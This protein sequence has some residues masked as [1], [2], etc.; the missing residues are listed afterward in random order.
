MIRD[1]LRTRGLVAA[2]GFLTVAGMLGASVL[3][4]QAIETQ[5][6]QEQWGSKES[7]YSAAVKRAMALVQEAM[8]ASQESL[9][10]AKERVAKRQE[11]TVRKLHEHLRLIQEDDVPRVRQRHLRLR[12][13]GLRRIS[14]HRGGMSAEGILAQAEHLGLSDEQVD[15][16]RGA[17]KAHRRAGITRKAEIEIA[18]LDLKEMLADADTAD[19]NAVEA[20]MQE[21]AGFKVAD[22]IAELRL[23]QQVRGVLSPEQ[24]EQ[25]E[26][27]RGH[28]FFML[29][30]GGE[31]P[32]V[33]R[34]GD[35][36]QAFDFD[37]DFDFDTLESLDWVEEF[38][39][40]P[41][42]I[43]FKSKEESSKSGEDEG[44]EHE[45]VSGKTSKSGF[46][47]VTL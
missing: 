2:I 27:E 15:Q 5:E 38:G 16:I 23:R 18:E 10:R 20:K 24:R 41:F 7:T 36:D 21:I 25:L 34:F 47:V 39:D 3:V 22:R 6:R 4:A 1:K 11:I 12:L 19:L 30:R 31:G 17:S 42:G 43:F 45:G 8:A 26:D 40:L 44:E 32:H 33:L 37:F 14:L 35:G 46:G 9:Q 28:N 29:R 13:P